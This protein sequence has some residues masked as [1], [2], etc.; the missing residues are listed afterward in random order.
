MIITETNNEIVIDNFKRMTIDRMILLRYLPIVINK[1]GISIVKLSKIILG[2]I[3]LEEIS[4]YE[5]YAIC[6][7]FT[8][9]N[10]EERR[11]FKEVD[12]SEIEVDFNSRT[13]KG[14]HHVEKERVLEIIPDRY[15]TIRSSVKELDQLVQCGIIKQ[16]DIIKDTLISISGQKGNLRYGSQKSIDNIKAMI[17][18]K[19]YLSVPVTIATTEDI[20]NVEENGLNLSMGFELVD[21]YHTF[22]ALR[23]ID[24][25]NDFPVILNVLKLYNKEETRS[26]IIQMDYKNKVWRDRWK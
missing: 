4:L 17:L 5:Y 16:T 2:Q 21:G 11:Y 8:A 9:Y 25:E 6:Y 24:K 20:L 1:F 14:S 23:G 18:Q 13:I 26:V 15:Y 22:M 12:I 19:R 7:G 10:K 3:R